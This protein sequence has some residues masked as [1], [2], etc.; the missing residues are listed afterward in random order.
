VLKMVEKCAGNIQTASNPEHLK[1]LNKAEIEK[2]LL[3]AYDLDG[4]KEIQWAE[5]N[6]FN[7]LL[8]KQ[9]KDLRPIFRFFDKNH[10]WV[11]EH[12]EIQKSKPKQLL[13]FLGTGKRK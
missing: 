5:Y 10:N 2:E 6:I 4:D 11:I 12:K 7:H 13:G 8:K 9:S 3:E 1:N